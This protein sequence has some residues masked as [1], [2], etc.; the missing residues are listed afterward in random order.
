MNPCTVCPAIILAIIGLFDGSCAAPA[1]IT[2]SPGVSIAGTVSLFPTPGTFVIPV[3]NLLLC[4]SP[5]ILP[6]LPTGPVNP[7]CAA[8]AFLYAN[9]REFTADASDVNVCLSL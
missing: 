4:G 7:T 5:F 1:G 9:A 2:A 6:A 8:I 3:A